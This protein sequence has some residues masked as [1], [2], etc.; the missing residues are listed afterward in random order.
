MR[1]ATLCGPVSAALVWWSA[2]QTCLDAQEGLCWFSGSYPNPRGESPDRRSGVTPPRKPALLPQ[3]EVRCSPSATSCGLNGLWA[4]GSHR[5]PESG[6]LSR[7]VGCKPVPQS[8]SHCRPPADQQSPSPASQRPP[9]EKVHTCGSVP[10]ASRRGFP[11]K[12]AG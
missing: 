6:I 8:G 11:R 12:T 2:Y 1:R 3:V 5:L 9:C 4:H 10:Q 7:L